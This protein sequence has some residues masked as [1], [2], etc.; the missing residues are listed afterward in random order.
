MDWLT[1]SLDLSWIKILWAF[2]KKRLSQR[3]DLTKDNFLDVVKHEWDNMDEHQY[4]Q[5]FESIQQ[6]LRDCIQREGAWTKY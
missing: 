2:W 4:Q 6:R 5:T 1:R 3:T